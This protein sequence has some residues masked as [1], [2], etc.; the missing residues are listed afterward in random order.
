MQLNGFFLRRAASLSYYSCAALEQIPGLVHGF[1]TRSGGVSLAPENAL[2]LGYTPWD[3][4]AHVQENRRRFLSALNLLPEHLATVAQVHS[5]EFH[6][7]QGPAY[8]WNPRTRGDALVT[9]MENVAV[10]V[11]VADCFPVLIAD[12]RSGVIAAVHAGWRG[13]AARILE[14]T[15]EGMHGDLGI[16]L[17]DVIVAIGPGIRSCCLEVGVE[18]QSA[19]AAEFSRAHLCSQHPAHQGKYLLDLP[20]ALNIQLSEAG[21]PSGNVHD[22]GLCTRCH[23]DQF[24]SYR[25][26]GSRTG[27][28]MAVIARAVEVQQA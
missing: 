27:R 14:H 17:A 7:I 1:S 9:V 25:A 26:E 10:A 13:T 23:P 5:A 8:Q 24:F 4:P 19:F 3:V 18:V 28:M 11:Q 6:I 2:N 20:L 21:I 15:L 16:D 22:L 12:P